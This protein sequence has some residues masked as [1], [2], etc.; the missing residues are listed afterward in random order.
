MRNRILK[1]LKL[2]SLSTVIVFSSCQK[3][4]D[5]FSTLENWKLPED[6]LDL[7]LEENEFITVSKEYI[8]EE[9]YL[10]RNLYLG[11]DKDIR[12][13]VNY[14][15]DVYDFDTV[16]SMKIDFGSDSLD[17]TP[18]NLYR[19]G[20]GLLEKEKLEKVLGQ[21]RMFY[22]APDYTFKSKKHFD[23]VNDAISFEESGIRLAGIDTSST[24]FKLELEDKVYPNQSYYLIWK[25]TGFNL[26]IHY[27]F[28]LRNSTY[29]S[30]FIKYDSE[31]YGE[32]ILKRR[33]AIKSEATPNDYVT[34]S[35][36]LDPFTSISYSRTDQVNILITDIGHNLEEDQRNIK[37]FKFNILFRDEYEKLLTKI[38]NI[39]IEPPYVLEAPDLMGGWVKVLTEDYY[40]KKR[41]NRYNS[42]FAGLENRQNTAK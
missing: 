17:F 19:P 39:E 26:V 32:E 21:Y 7:Y 27:R 22:G 8:D 14:N 12:G 20:K 30:A 37:K 28:D 3:N 25:E 6:Q 16:F 2:C 18:K 13:I 35:L 33:I 40:F 11:K 10:F 31:N 1:C 15:A 41:Y 4:K 23:L 36:Y 5:P 42:K 34:M 29:S 9:E 38:D 24:F